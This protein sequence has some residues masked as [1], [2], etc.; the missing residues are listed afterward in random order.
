MKF[1]FFTHMPWPEGRTP[2]Q[3]IG[4]TTEQVQHAEELGFCS[5]WLAEHHFTRYCIGSSTL[6]IAANLAAHTKTIRLGT[7]VLVSPLHNPLRLAEDIA[8]LDLVSSGRVDVGFGRGSGGYEYHGY[9]VERDESQQRFRESIR[10]LEGLWT[11]PD[12]TFNGEHYQVNQVNLVPPPVQKPHPP[13]YLAATRTPETL[14]FAVSTGHNL[15]IAVVQ[16]TAAALDL[17]QRFV[18]KSGEA[19]FNIPMSS[20]PF[21]RYCYVAETEEQAIK[22]TRDKLN[23]VVD[24]MQ[25]RNNIPVGSELHLKMSDWRESR[26]EL[27]ATFDYLNANRA[28]IGTP[29]QCVAQIN[30]FRKIGIDYFGCNFDFGGMAHDKVVRSMDLFASEVMPRLI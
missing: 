4:E 12:F 14:D 3:I 10:I 30:E 23:W 22:D 26:T 15:C 9:N 6:V 28:V 16:D 24:I 5:A 27:P 11:T 1:G 7:A 8:T 17:C 25:W 21:F 19:G 29:D 20:I 18:D 13:I 2:D